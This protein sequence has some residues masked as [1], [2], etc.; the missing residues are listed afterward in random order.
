MLHLCHI[1]KLIVDGLYY[2]AFSEQY[3]VRNDHKRV[4]HLVFKFG[5]QLNAIN[6]ELAEQVFAD[7]ATVT[8]QLAIKLFCEMR[9]FQRFP[10]VNVSWGEHK[11][12]NF[13][14]LVA[15]DMQLKS[16]EPSHRAFAP[17]SNASEGLML[18]YSLVLAHSQRGAIDKTYTSAFAHKYLFYKDGKFHNG[19]SFQFHE[20]IVRH[21][22]RKKVAHIFAHILNIEMLQASVS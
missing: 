19:A 1:L 21:C 9:Y 11:V 16:I 18:E 17:L 12:N 4:L 10:I 20:S 13:A 2:G 7:V 14:H 8:D 5:Y 15:N 22:F 3:L 6:K